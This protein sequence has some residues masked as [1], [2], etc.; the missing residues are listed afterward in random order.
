[1]LSETQEKESTDSNKQ[2]DEDVKAQANIPTLSPSSLLTPESSSSEAVQSNHFW[3]ESEYLNNEDSNEDE[4]AKENEIKMDEILSCLNGVAVTKESDNGCDD[5]GKV[6]NLWHLRQL[7]ITRHGLV[8]ASIRKRV[9]PKLVGANE[10]ILTASFT[11]LPSLF[12]RSEVSDSIK[13]SKINDLTNSDVEMIKN[14]IQDC[15]WSI[16][17]EIKAVRQQRNHERGEKRSLGLNVRRGFDGDSSVTS[18]DSGCSSITTGKITPQLIPECIRAFP[19]L[20]TAVA[21]PYV[22]GTSSPVSGIATPNTVPS[23]TPYGIQN[24]SI[25]EN[26]VVPTVITN[27]RKSRRKQKEEQAL[28]L[29]IITSILRTVPEEKNFDECDFDADDDTVVADNTNKLY[30]FKGMHNLIAPLLITLES[31]S[32]TSLIFNRLAQSH[33]RDAMGLTFDGIQA[34]IRLVFMTLLKRV[35]KGL[36]DYLLRGGLEDPCVFALP[37][38]LCWFSSDIPNY[39]IIS[40][41]FDVFIATHA[42]FPIYLSVAMLT[43]PSSKEL[44]MM[45]PCKHSALVTVMRSLPACSASHSNAINIFEDIIELAISYM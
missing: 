25:N 16:E 3:A 31:P 22:S 7:A 45:T 14:D 23:I 32:L 21:S 2:Y 4:K 1:M 8:N 36:H 28:L 44:I 6:V 40:R 17:K 10:Q 5:E 35:D 29:S 42:S 15:V 33:L 24:M 41:L 19:R 12:S 26:S 27:V 43:Y 9:W 13:A 39:E 37:W 38:V 34:S 18:L 30:Y 11:S 20:S